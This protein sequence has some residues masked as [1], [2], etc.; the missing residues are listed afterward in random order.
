MI[1]TYCL[2][3]KILQIYSLPEGVFGFI[4]SIAYSC[5]ILMFQNSH[6]F[7]NLMKLT[8]IV[9]LRWTDQMTRIVAL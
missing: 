9:E 1:I 7:R 5:W 4:Y 2:S 8:R 6:A 3:T